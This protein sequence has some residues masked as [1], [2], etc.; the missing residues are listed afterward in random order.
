MKIC[1]FVIFCSR[2]IWEVIWHRLNCFSGF[3]WC[4]ADIIYF[5]LL[6]CEWVTEWNRNAG[7]APREVRG[8]FCMRTPQHGCFVYVCFVLFYNRK[9]FVFIEFFCLCMI[10]VGRVIV[11]STCPSVPFFETPYLRNTLMEFLQI[12]HKGP[13]GL[14][15]ESISLMLNTKTWIHTLIMSKFY[16]IVEVNQ[17]KWWDFLFKKVKSV[18]YH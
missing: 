12:W 10:S 8:T 17:I 1:S 7:R 2:G 3:H 11:F 9:H 15:D 14:K 6:R 18:I 16:T 5:R 13:L 4:S